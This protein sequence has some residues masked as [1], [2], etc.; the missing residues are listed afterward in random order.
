MGKACEYYLDSSKDVDNPQLELAQRCLDLIPE[1]ASDHLQAYRDM[2]TAL[3]MLSEFGVS[4]LPIV[5]RH[6]TNYD[7]LVK[8]ILHVDPMA[9]KSA[10][11]ILRMIKLAG[12][13]E[14]SRRPPLDEAPILSVIADYALKAIR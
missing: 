9:Y 13:L 14:K 3:G 12:N 11:K 6:M 7:P 5:V 2:L 8:K 10:R 4:I 1:G